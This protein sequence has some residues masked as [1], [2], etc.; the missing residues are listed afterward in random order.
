LESIQSILDELEK[1]E[2]I[3]FKKNPFAA[4]PTP[5]LKKALNL[6]EEFA[7]E[8]FTSDDLT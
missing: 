6:I 3:D 8:N 5:A 2:D 1:I 4:I 7:E